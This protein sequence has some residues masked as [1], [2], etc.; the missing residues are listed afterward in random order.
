MVEKLEAGKFYMGCGCSPMKAMYFPSI[1]KGKRTVVLQQ[2]GGSVY[3][4]YAWRVTEIQAEDLLM[5]ATEYDR[6]GYHEDSDTLRRWANGIPPKKVYA[7]YPKSQRYRRS[8]AM[9]LGVEADSIEE[10]YAI[11]KEK[12]YAPMTQEKGS[13]FK[14][15]D[16]EFDIVESPFSET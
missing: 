10:A 9:G 16:L 11:F 5:W 6:H 12:A 15:E 7:V 14:L 2:T 4:A 8:N 13:I 3:Y 1:E